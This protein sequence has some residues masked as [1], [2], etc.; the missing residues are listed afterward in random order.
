MAD[1]KSS[2]YLAECSPLVNPVYVGSEYRWL[3]GLQVAPQLQLEATCLTWSYYTHSANVWRGLELEPL[4]FRHPDESL[5]V[6]DLL[7][8]AC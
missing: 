7:I 3:L 6:S 8:E 1:Y 2:L 4:S 5:A